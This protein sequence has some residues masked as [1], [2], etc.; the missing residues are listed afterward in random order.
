MTYAKS[1]VLN[2]RAQQII[3]GGHHLSGRPLL[4]PFD[5]PMY[6]ARAKGARI[7]DVD[8]NEYIDYV[9]AYGA[10]LLGYANEEV[11]AA[12]VAQLRAGSLVSLNH[13]MHVEFI[14]ALLPRFGAEMGVFVK[15][16]SDA[17][18]AALRI[19]RRATGRTKIARCGYHGWHD[20]C[21]PEDGFVPAGLRDQ[22]FEFSAREPASLHRLL[23]E[24]QL[25]AVIL[26]PEMMCPPDRS[27]FVHLIE[28]KRR[29]GAVFILDEI[30]TAFR[31]P[32]GSLQRHLDIH[33]DLTTVSKALGNG[34]PIGAVLGPRAV[35]E[36]A[37]GMHL[38]AT[39]HGD[40]ASMA[41][42]MATMRI[43]DREPVAEHV[44]RLGQ[45]LID[46]LG[47]SARRHGVDASAYGEP[48][49]PMPFLRFAEDRTRDR[50]YRAV[51]AGGILLHPRHLWFVS[52][53]HTD[54]DIDRTL[55]VC[56]TAFR[57]V[58]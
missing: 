26:A 14:E 23:S 17:T 49:P 34:W 54:A 2:E 47:E 1:A 39:Y 22:V 42:A 50:F 15:T 12:A 38:S 5:S 33:P 51:L 53:A 24:H 28:A 19:A 55:E 27:T 11:D 6:F 25:A 31:T 35:L 29:A 40:T 36:H 45:R 13:P 7:W 52:H 41:A 16:G 46:G 3:P 10:I 37:A 18:T 56:D 8:G 43:L 44:W 48:L 57:E 9:L 20:W 30:K 21:L 32:P 58:A 4:S